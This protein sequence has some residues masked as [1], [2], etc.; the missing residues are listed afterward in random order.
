MYG[1]VAQIRLKPGKEAEL[2]RLAHA[3]SEFAPGLRFDFLYRTDAD[4]R[5][6]VLVVAFTDKQT[7][8][9]NAATPEQHAQYLKYRALMESDPVWHDGEIVFAFPE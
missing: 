2:I 1:T 6:Y 8:E 4:P 5:E 7:Y 3:G 9:A